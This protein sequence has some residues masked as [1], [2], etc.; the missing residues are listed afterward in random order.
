M[1]S[2]APTLFDRFRR[3]PR[4]VQWLVLAAAG[5]ALFLAWDSYLSKLTDQMRSKAEQIE[6]SAFAVRRAASIAG[7]FRSMEDAV[8][9]L[10]PVD[11]PQQAANGAKALN[12]EINDVLKRHSIA[13]PVF[14]V[15]TTSKLPPGTLAS[16]TG[17][18]RLERLTVD[19]KFLATPED[20]TAVIA[21]LEASKVIDSVNAVSIAKDTNHKVKVNVSFESW[22]I[23]GDVAIGGR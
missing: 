5:L 11:L 22:V 18:K 4:A 2:E 23:A 7:E 15:H 17:G 3:W 19:L 8:Q 6:Q 16:V 12:I 13:N 10:G 20:T 14:N 1:T 9:S 21:D